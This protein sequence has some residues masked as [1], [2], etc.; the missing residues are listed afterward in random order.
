MLRA[1]LS[2]CQGLM[3]DCAGIAGNADESATARMLAAQTAAKLA[4]ASALTASAIARLA[5]AETHQRLANV[6]IELSL[7]PHGGTTHFRREPEY[8]ADSR[9]NP[10]PEKSTNNLPRVRSI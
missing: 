4:A 6:K 3:A 8:G 9:A 7:N 5:E 1:E 10:E 2:A